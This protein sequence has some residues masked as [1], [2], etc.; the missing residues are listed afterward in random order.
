MEHDC[1][2][3]IPSHGV[4]VNYK[5]GFTTQEGESQGKTGEQHREQYGRQ[6]DEDHISN[7]TA[8]WVS[9]VEARKRVPEKDN[10]SIAYGSD[11]SI[12]RTNKRLKKPQ[13]RGDGEQDYDHQARNLA[14]LELRV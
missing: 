3:F 1:V 9:V 4:R 12:D 14:S 5:S 8:E 7:E 10:E 2:Q 11:A 13:I 6:H